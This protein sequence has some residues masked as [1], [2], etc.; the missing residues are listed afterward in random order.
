MEAEGKQLYLEL[1]E[2]QYP[3]HTIESRGSLFLIVTIATVH[4]DSLTPAKFALI[5]VALF[6]SSSHFRLSF[7]PFHPALGPLVVPSITYPQT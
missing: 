6:L 7:A 3:F 1:P 4:V 5:F 2:Y